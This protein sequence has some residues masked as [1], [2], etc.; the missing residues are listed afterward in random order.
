MKALF[1]LKLI[2]YSPDPSQNFALII[3]YIYFTLCFKNISRMT[4]LHE[5]RPF[6]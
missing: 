4:V 6:P 1:C 3:G 2:L 5:K